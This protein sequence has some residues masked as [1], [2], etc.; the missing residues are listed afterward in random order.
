MAGDE[1][2]YKIAEVTATSRD[3]WRTF[4]NR[5]GVTPTALAEVLG[6][7]LAEMAATNRESDLPVLL[8]E[9]VQ[10]ARQ[11]AYERRRRDP[12]G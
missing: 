8:R 10:D 6:I 9:L 12:Q 5:F 4:G 11:V 2:R 1:R 7:R 3:G